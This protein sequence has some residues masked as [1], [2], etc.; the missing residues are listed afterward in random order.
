MLLLVGAEQ[1]VTAPQ[2]IWFGNGMAYCFQYVRE[3]V[4]KCVWNRLILTMEWLQLENGT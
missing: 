2:V 4:T 1:K 3:T